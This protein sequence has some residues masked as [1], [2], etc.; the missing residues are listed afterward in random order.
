MKNAV[1]TG[2]SRGLG[3]AL[4]KEFAQIGYRVFG[5]SRRAT[6][7]DELK[8]SFGSPHKFFTADST[9]QSALVD[10]ASLVKSEGGANL[11]IANAGVIN[12][13]TPLWEIEQ[14]VWD[15]A[16]SINLMGVVNTINAFLPDMIDRDTGTFIAISSGWGKSPSLGL[17][18]YCAGKYA[19]EGIIGCLVLDLENRK[20]RVNAI[21]LDPG[22]GIN[23]DMLAACL[24]EEHE[25]YEKA[26]QW[27]PRAAEFITKKII[28][29]RINGS[30]TVQ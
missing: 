28:S 4:A 5:T 19:V 14:S 22:G 3:N 12:S 2:C 25:E 24:P 16:L 7:T 21:S 23:T 15:E 27:A 10:F 6:D 13:R 9:D 11:V 30:Q 20:S 8:E 18:P 29:E 26:A 1:I 17:S